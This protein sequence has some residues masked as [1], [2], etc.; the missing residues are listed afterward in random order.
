MNPACIDMLEENKD[1]IDWINI[2]L[3][4]EIFTINYDAIKKRI[5]PLVE[6]IDDEMLSSNA[7]RESY[8]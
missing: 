6:D 7:C 8:C 2:S 1:K 4:P 5:E 3:N